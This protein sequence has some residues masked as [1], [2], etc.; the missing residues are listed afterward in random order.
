MILEYLNI[1]IDTCPTP[2]QITAKCAIS[3]R[4]DGQHLQKVNEMIHDEQIAI[5]GI[6]FINEGV[7]IK[8]SK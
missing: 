7:Y 1:D 6:Y 8:I 5:Q 3:I 2:K 4:F